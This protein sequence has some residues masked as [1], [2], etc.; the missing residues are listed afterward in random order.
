MGEPGGSFLFAMFFMFHQEDDNTPLPTSSG[1][2]QAL[3]LAWK[4]ASC[5]VPSL[6]S[7][8]GSMAV[9]F[10]AVSN[11]ITIERHAQALR[12]LAE[13]GSNW[14]QLDDVTL[15]LHRALLPDATS[16][17]AQVD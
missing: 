4:N 10:L 11:A 14:S 8:V 13:A 15:S 3:Y 9:C 16:E 5:V 2:E 1:H 12:R 17:L 7:S 6:W